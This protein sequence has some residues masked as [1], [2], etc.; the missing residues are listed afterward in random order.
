VKH[1]LWEIWKDE[2]LARHPWKV[3][4]INYIAYFSSKEAAERQVAAWKAERRKLGL[5]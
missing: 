1:E 2:D 5:K 3:Q 4:A